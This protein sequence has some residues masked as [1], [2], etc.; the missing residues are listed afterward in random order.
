MNWLGTDM[1]DNT[2]FWIRFSEELLLL[3]SHFA[4]QNF[5]IPVFRVYL[6]CSASLN[7]RSRTK[8]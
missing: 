4:N 2:M 6:V 5:C 3:C 7:Y 1:L 8:N